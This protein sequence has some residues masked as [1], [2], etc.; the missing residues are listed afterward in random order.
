[1]FQRLF[2]VFC[3]CLSGSRLPV[4]R[5]VVSRSGIL[6]PLTTGTHNRHSQPALTTGTHSRH[7]QPALTTVTYN[8]HSQLSL[9]FVTHN[10]H[11]QLSLTTVTHI[12]YTLLHLWL[13]H[14]VCLILPADSGVLSDL[15]R[16]LLIPDQAFIFSIKSRK[17]IMSETIVDKTPVS[18]VIIGGVGFDSAADERTET[19]DTDFGVVSATE[20]MIRGDDGQNFRV[21]MI[22]RHQGKVHVPPGS[23]N[24]RALVRAAAVFGAPVLSLNSVGTMKGH[25]PGTFFIPDDFIDMTKDRVRTFFTDET[26]HVDMSDP[27]C[28]TIRNPLKEVLR[29]K[30]IPF[31][32]GV[33]VATEGP[34]FETKAEIRMYAAF[35]DVVGMTGIPETVLA[36]EAGLCYASLCLITNPACGLAEKSEEIL[37]SEEIAESVAES[38]KRIYDV[39]GSLLPKLRNKE[40]CRCSEAPSVG[41]L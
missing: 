26:V 13:F 11:S 20:M 10:C 37:T 6:M 14:A 27:Y 36:K 41:R 3:D 39:V 2:F 31:G 18:L 8:C 28:R 17:L 22:P 30:N 15:L 16:Y 12:C 9:I 35:S 38:Q 25:P 5:A 40:K 7:S 32:E 24:Y 34:R 19:I 4:C 29:E 33:Y 23:I 1:M 21:V